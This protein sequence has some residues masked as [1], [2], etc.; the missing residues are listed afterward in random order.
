MLTSENAL[1]TFI[2]GL[3]SKMSPRTA[4]VHFSSPAFRSLYPA[5]NAVIKLKCD[6]H[7]HPEW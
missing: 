7:H 5:D 2:V 6:T 3:A 1:S 4:F